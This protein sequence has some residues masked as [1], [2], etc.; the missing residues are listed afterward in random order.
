MAAIAWVM[1]AK[2]T[3]PT[4]RLNMATPMIAAS[5]T[6]T[7]TTASRAKGRLWKGSHHQGSAVT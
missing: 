3:P 7:S 1:I 2:Y 4:R 5:S 6:G